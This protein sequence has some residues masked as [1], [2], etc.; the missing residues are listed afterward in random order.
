M[1]RYHGARNFVVASGCSYSCHHHPRAHLA[2]TQNDHGD[3]RWEFRIEPHAEPKI[4]A[5][6]G[7]FRRLRDLTVR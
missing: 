7:T 1:E 2:L 6:E 4:P 5:L 3:V